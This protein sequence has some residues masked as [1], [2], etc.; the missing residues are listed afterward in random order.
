MDIEQIVEELREVKATMAEA[1][2]KLDTLIFNFNM[3]HTAQVH[4]SVELRA[5]QAQCS[6][7]SLKC[8]VL[9]ASYPPPAPPTPTPTPTGGGAP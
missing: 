2:A 9:A 7:R 8:P 4:Q 5:L 6:Q 3:V 1:V